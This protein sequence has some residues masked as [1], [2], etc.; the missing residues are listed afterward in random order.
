QLT[1]D[2]E[3]REIAGYE[4]RLVPVDADRLASDPTIEKKNAAYRASYPHITE[5]VGRT[6]A[7]LNRRYF[8]ESD[9]GNLMADIMVEM[10]G[11]DIGLMHPGGIRKDLPKGD[12][13]VVD[14]LDTNP[15]VDP[16]TVVEM[17]GVQLKAALEQSFTQLR[18]LMQ[19]SSRLRVVY[20]TSRP[21][22]QRLV[23]L[24]FDGN[25]VADDDVFRAAVAGIIAR[26]GDHYDV[27]L[28]TKLLEEHPPLGEITIDYFRKYGTVPTPES[29]RQ[30]DLAASAR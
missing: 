1:L 20:D 23:S 27:F 4:G 2:A 5:V 12:V 6:E 19:V 25:P 22:R 15:F 17:T 8:D 29:G 30:T 11:A 13:E 21:E 10:T 16:S 24:H 7:R 26:G 3:T 28:E 14:I 18:G 9:L